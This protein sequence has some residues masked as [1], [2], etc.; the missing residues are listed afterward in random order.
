M[1]RNDTTNIKALEEGLINSNNV[2]SMSSGQ[3]FH[4]LNNKLGDP[5]THA[6]AEIWFP[7]AQKVQQY[8][9]E[10][11][12]FIE[13][14]KKDGALNDSKINSLYDRMMKYKKDVLSTDSAI[15]ETFSNKLTLITKSFDESNSNIDWFKK[16]FF[17]HV[18]KEAFSA[19][20]TKFQNNVKIIENKLVSFCNQKV[21]N[22]AFI[23]D[24][25]E[26][27][28][29]QNST[30]VKAGEKIEITAGVGSFSTL[31]KPIININHK[32]M[33]LNES[34]AGVYSFEASAKSG[35]HIIPVKIEF[36]DQ[37]GKQNVFEKKIE[38]TVAK[39]CDQ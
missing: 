10:I 34:G 36:T 15:L 23:I 4:E 28:V 19:I 39:P 5:G 6:K 1:G 17:S 30:Y 32:N 22:N 26:P 3:A 38:Y 7:C 35:K 27:L 18:S 24:V 9:E 12:N 14:L 13:E 31:C 37:D 11:F 33:T 16:T 20:L 2:I 29:V 8:S 25:F 21:S